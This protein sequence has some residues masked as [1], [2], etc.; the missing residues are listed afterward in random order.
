LWWL[1]WLIKPWPFCHVTLNFPGV[2]CQAFTTQAS[3]SKPSCHPDPTTLPLCLLRLSLLEATHIF[4]ISHTQRTPSTPPLHLQLLLSSSDIPAPSPTF[5]P[6]APAPTSTL[7][8]LQTL[9]TR[10]HTHK[11]NDGSLARPLSVGNPVRLRGRFRHGGPS[12]PLLSVFASS[13]SIFF[14]TL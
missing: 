12:T 14:L 11:F 1:W 2:Q 3:S 10:T 5:L 6:P 4:Q 8:T 9:R 7:V 13:L